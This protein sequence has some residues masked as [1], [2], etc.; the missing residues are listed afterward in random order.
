MGLALVQSRALLGL[1]APGVTVEVH[2]AN[3]L[4]SFTLVGLAEVEVKEARERVRAAIVNAGLEFPN[5]QRITVNLA[6]ADLPK[7]SG[8]FDLPIA[9]GILAASGQIDAQRLADYEFAGELSLTGALRPVRGALATALALQRQQHRVRLVLPPDSAQEAAFVPAIQVF[10][11]AHL[12]DVVRQFIAHDATLAEQGDDVEGWQRVHSIPAEASL[13]SLDLREV[14]GQMQAKRALEIAAAGAHGVLMIGP[15]GS[16][17]SM[18]AQRF[19]SLLPGMT[20]EEALEAAAIASLSG[21]FTPQLWRQRPFA[22]PHHT[23][24]SIALVGGG[25]PPRPGEISYAHCGALFLDELPEFARSALEALREPLETGRI[26][27]ARAAQRAEFPARF[28]LVAAMN[29]CPCGYWGSRIRACRCSPDQ[30]ARYQARISGPL[31]DRID[32]HVEVAALSPEELLAAPEGESSEAVQQ[33][34][35]AAR[36][37]ALRRQGLPNHQLQG[38]Q[39]DTHLQLQ[40]EALAFA[41]KAATRLGWSA[42]G[43]HRALKVARTIADLAGSDAITQAHLAEALQYRRALMQP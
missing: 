7:D 32:L 5:N 37:R 20:D 19:A 1:Q 14:R 33:R 36:D 10:S 35:S 30:V 6:P 15:P 39:L 25:S 2:L 27:I 23:A 18:L 43:T 41:H 4:P 3:G 29:P 38:V 9:L 12:L 40:P 34:V 21:R 31:L 24:S 16:G 42:R 17:K 26:T 28:Q 13:Q 22:A 8:R 11:A